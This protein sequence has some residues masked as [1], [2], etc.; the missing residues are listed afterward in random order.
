MEPHNLSLVLTMR[1]C[2]TILIIAAVVEDIG[3][4]KRVVYLA[5]LLLQGDEEG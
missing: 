3:R 2:W 1:T 5:D 4:L